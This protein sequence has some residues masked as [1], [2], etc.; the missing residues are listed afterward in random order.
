[1]QLSSTQGSDKPRASR[2]SRIPG[3]VRAELRKALGANPWFWLPLAVGC[4]L[5]IGSAAYCYTIFRNTLQL[6]LS[7]NKSYSSLGCFAL[8]MPVYNYGIFFGVFTLTWPLLVA[9]PYA[10]SWG[11]ERRRGVLQQ[12]ALR[13]S[14][15]RCYRAKATAAFI[16]GALVV[17]VP[18]LLNLIICACFAPAAPVW[19]SDQGYIGIF[20]DA[21]LSSLFYQHPFVF[22]L[23]WSVIA[24]IIAGLWA[25]TVLVFTLF[26]R[27]PAEA[28]IG[29]YVVLYLLAFISAQVRSAIAGVVGRNQS[30]LNILGW[31][32]L[33]LNLFQVLSPST[34][35]G[36]TEWL[37]IVLVL[38]ALA[39]IIV[40]LLHR[41]EDLL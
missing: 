14:R 31:D 6:S 15:K 2:P 28:I 36:G 9:A 30:A 26:I 5:A 38:L 16:S 37:I 8:W 23:V 18:Y 10:W 24:S 7:L 22:C 27:R 12:E 13:T 35:R 41:R 40:P 33:S 21:P 32:P 25:T 34:G 20:Q 17:L 19:A 4:A 1:M 11:V 29:S 3:I 39:S